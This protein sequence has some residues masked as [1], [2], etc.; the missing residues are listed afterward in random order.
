[1]RACVNLLVVALLSGAL[2]LPACVDQRAS[3]SH[4]M[5]VGLR[6][7]GG[8]TPPTIPLAPVSLTTQ[9][10]F[11]S[12]ENSAL[13]RMAPADL[14]P[15]LEDLAAD[16]NPSERPQDV[17]LLQRL[18]LLHLRSGQGSSRL[19][20]AFA[21]ADRLRQE[22]ANSPHTL[23]LLAHITQILLRKSSDGAFHL[24]AQRLDV[25]QRLSTSWEALLTVA[26]DYVGPHGRKA[27]DI[28]L[29]LA[30]LRGALDGVGKQPPGSPTDVPGTTL[31]LGDASQVEA[32]RVLR[33]LDTGSDGDK[34]S[35]C[36]E[37]ERQKA[38]KSLSGTPALWLNL[39]C[40]I[41]LRSPD[42]GLASLTALVSAGAVDAPCRW[43]TRIVGGS[44]AGRAAL[45][46]AMRERGLSGCEN[47]G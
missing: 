18:A 27:A 20:R 2:A 4:S 17:I 9:A 25:A 38:K 8:A 45:A 24:N 39:R 19:Q 37:W 28:Q 15:I 16:A 23:Y 12:F 36:G 13:E 44:E 43:L 41:V 3:T 10:E 14:I 31:T 11:D 1:M 5:E 35:L 6:D 22:V 42:Q 47:G 7:I 30:A 29:E 26:P 46:A 21:V 40:S 33:G 32:R 34:V